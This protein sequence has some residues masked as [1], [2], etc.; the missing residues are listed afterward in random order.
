M[1]NITGS[2]STVR[3]GV[4]YSGTNDAEGAFT[5]KASAP[6]VGGGTTSMGA[7]AQGI[8][9]DASLSSPVYQSV[10]EVRPTNYAIN[11]YIK[12]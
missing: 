9:L 7:Q 5:T 2:I 11:Y 10:E 12:Y 3:N 8:R 6:N 1:P 4:S